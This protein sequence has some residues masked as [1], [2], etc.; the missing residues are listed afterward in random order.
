MGDDDGGI[1]TADGD[2]RQS[3]GSVGRLEG[4]FH[5]VQ[6]ALRTEDGNVVVVVAVE[7]SGVCKIMK[8]EWRGRSW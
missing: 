7:E 5:L 4:I 8:N 1:G 6:P 3:R 2:A